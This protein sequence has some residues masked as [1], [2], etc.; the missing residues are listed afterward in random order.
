MAVE[1]QSSLLGFYIHLSRV[2][3]GI[4]FQQTSSYSIRRLCVTAFFAFY[5]MYY[6]VHTNQTMD[7][8]KS[9]LKMWSDLIAQGEVSF[10]GN[11]YRSSTQVFN[12]YFDLFYNHG[13]IPTA[14][15]LVLLCFLFQQSIALAEVNQNQLNFAIILFTVVFSFFHVTLL[16][17]RMSLLIFLF[18][19]CIFYCWRQTRCGQ[20]RD[21]K[22]TSISISKQKMLADLENA[23]RNAKPFLNS[24]RN[25]DG[26]GYVTG[27]PAKGAVH[28]IATLLHLTIH[29]DI[30]TQNDGLKISDDL[31]QNLQSL[32]RQFPKIEDRYK[33]KLYLQTLC[34][35]LNALDLL[36]SLDDQIVNTTIEDMSKLSVSPYL[37]AHG[38]DIGRP[39]S[40]NFALFIAQVMIFAKKLGIRNTDNSMNDWITFHKNTMNNIGFWGPSESRP[41]LQ[42]QNGFHQYEVFSFLGVDDVPWDKCAKHVA[43]LGQKEARFAPYPGGGACFDY[44]A[45]FFLTS[46]FLS[47]EPS[48]TPYWNAHSKKS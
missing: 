44:D 5:N 42:F 17:N 39:G 16:T 29:N 35:S 4:K 32:N 48:I 37:H 46:P 26:W 14:L 47:K 41:Y 43:T 36:K 33:S 6:S 31:C 10:F 45:I 38:C 21:N 24:C 2:L 11:G 1:R 34:F 28:P 19:L 13:V 18:L 20:K 15:L 12:Q 9:R 8:N 22:L 27:A 40:G 3:L 30:R 25:I 23:K 7:N